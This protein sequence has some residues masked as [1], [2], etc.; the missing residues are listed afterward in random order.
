VRDTAPEALR[1]QLGV[2]AVD[3]AQMLP[4]LREALPGLPEPV[5]VDADGARF[6]LLDATAAVLRT[7][8]AAQP[9]LLVL[10]DV[11]AADPASLALLRFLARELGS[12]HLLVLAAYRNVDPVPGQ[13][14]TEMLVEATREP[15][16]RRLSLAG[17]TEPQVLEYLQR[18]A[19]GI[20]S[21]EL[22]AAVHEQSEGNALFVGEAVRLLRLEGV[23]PDSGPELGLAIPETVRDVIQRR[24]TH[25]SGDCNRVLLLASVVGREFP[26][27]AIA[28]LDGVPVDELL[29]RLDEAVAAR[30]VSDVPGSPGRLRF[31]HVLIRDTLYD[32]LPAARRVRLHRRVAQTLEDLYGESLDGH[33]ETPERIIAGTA[34]VDR[35]RR[36]ARGLV[37]PPR[38]RASAA[39]LRHL[40][41]GRC[42][43]TCDRPSP[44]AAGEPRTRRAGAGPDDDAGGGTRLGLH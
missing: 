18:M 19:P 42:A 15:P 29:D 11:H 21:P 10:D 31:A 38:S 6:R 25:L 28:R 27:E 9:T 3:L 2:G 33:G 37:L 35:R 41:R 20:A 12:M 1:A 32:G 17:L 23:A 36:R 22:A 13:P 40:R 26:V 24:L 16:T 7:V 34:L 5:P 44:R 8:S 4:E 43:D 14:L 39:R 30:V